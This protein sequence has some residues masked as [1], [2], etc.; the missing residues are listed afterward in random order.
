MLTKK[1]ASLFSAGDDDQSI[2]GF[3][4]A[5][6][7]GIR[8]FTNDYIESKEFIFTECF[9]C[10][11]EVLDISLRVIEQDYTR[12]PKQLIS[13]TENSGSVHLLRFPN[14][15][16]E[17]GKI[18]KLIYQLNQEYRIPY[19]EIIILF[20]TDHNEVFSSKIVEHLV[21][22][23][24]PLITKASQFSILDT[25][26]GRYF[27]SLVKILQNRKNDLAIRTILDS[28][29][30]IGPKTIDK[31]YSIAVSEDRRFGSVCEDIANGSYGD[32][33]QINRARKILKMLFEFDW[34]TVKNMESFNEQVKSILQLIP[35]VTSEFEDELNTFLESMSIESV[36]DFYYLVNDIVGSTEQDLGEIDAV[37][38]MSMHQAK[39]LSADAVF[40]I[41]AEDEYIPGKG[42]PDEE[43][44]L[45]YVS[46]TRERRFLF[47]SHCNQRIG[48][49]AYTGAGR[50]NV[51]KL[52][53]FL[54]D[55]GLSSEA[56]TSFE[57][58]G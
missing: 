27:A 20:R 41:A 8:S 14:Q 31:I 19:S 30:G 9:R 46:M 2:Y 50:G 28:S 51:R 38:L 17:S 3:R 21:D 16:M 15:D 52:T 33:D 25:I 43:R 7:E 56:G 32:V 36:D 55:I 13:K 22:S 48:Q 37:R 6:P 11:K 42:N 45:L 58:K 12:I 23:G 39:G 29:N 35:S 49:Q 10:G 34:E 4:F 18:A 57:L 47:I 54:S 26:L 24:I 44:R 53:R 5:F 40:I 1:G